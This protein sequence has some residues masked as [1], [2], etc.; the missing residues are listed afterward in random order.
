M[1][2]LLCLIMLF[3]PLPRVTTR[4]SLCFAESFL[5]WGQSFIK[6]DF[7]LGLIIHPLLQPSLLRGPFVSSY[8]SLIIWRRK[9]SACLEASGQEFK[10]T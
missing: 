1:E 3:L 7:H 5:A 4:M 9:I 6:G 2:S 8:H 10:K